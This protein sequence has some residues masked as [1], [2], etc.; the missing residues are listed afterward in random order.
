MSIA[1]AYSCLHMIIAPARAAQ[2]FVGR[3]GD[4]V[5]IGKGRRMGATGDQAG[6][7]GHIDHEHGT[8]GIGDLA[9]LGEIKHARI[10][11]MACDK[12]FRCTGQAPFHGWCRS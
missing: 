4:D 11:R 1:A 7:V 3:G 10:G 6:K 12:D 8:A 9:E 5:S 2:G